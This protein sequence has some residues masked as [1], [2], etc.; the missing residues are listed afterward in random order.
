M[1]D[2]FN[3]LID[4]Q[5][6]F[7]SGIYELQELSSS[8]SCSTLHRN[9]KLPAMSEQLELPLEHTIQCPMCKKH[10]PEKD[11]HPDDQLCSKCECRMFARWKIVG[12]GLT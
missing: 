7:L 4:W 1:T 10:F 8:V 9:S 12:E 2:P 3:L 11:T 6:N 5:N